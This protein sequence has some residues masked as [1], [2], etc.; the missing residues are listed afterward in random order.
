MDLWFFHTLEVPYSAICVIL[1]NHIGSQCRCFNSFVPHSAICISLHYYMCISYHT[2]FLTSTLKFRVS[3]LHCGFFVSL[4]SSFYLHH[5]SLLCQLHCVIPCTWPNFSLS[6]NYFPHQNDIHSSFQIQSITISPKSILSFQVRLTIPFTWSKPLCL[7]I[8]LLVLAPF[9]VYFN[10]LFYKVHINRSVTTCSTPSYMF[11]IPTVLLSCQSCKAHRQTF[12]YVFWLQHTTWFTRT[13]QLCTF[14]LS[15]W[16]AI[17]SVIL[18]WPDLNFGP[19]HCQCVISRCGK[20]RGI[21][22]LL[23]SICDLFSSSKSKFRK[24]MC[25]DREHKQQLW[26]GIMRSAVQTPGNVQVDFP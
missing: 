19:S 5:V 2:L 21:I 14:K 18:I 4:S 10:T 12:I 7:L 8:N 20:S 24:P 17:K 6:F 23:C 22:I 16:E 13:P 3:S 9:Q 25:A 15:F 11:R 1:E 26:N